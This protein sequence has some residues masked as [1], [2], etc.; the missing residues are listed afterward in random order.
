MGRVPLLGEEE[1]QGSLHAGTQEGHV[2]RNR[3][4]GPPPAPTLPAPGPGNCE[5]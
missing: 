4:V 3:E 5:E 2:S 1:T